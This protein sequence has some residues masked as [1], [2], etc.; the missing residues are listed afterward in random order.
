MS[1]RTTLALLLPLALACG[2]ETVQAPPTPRFDWASF[3]D[4]SAGAPDAGRSRDY[5]LERAAV[6]AYVDALSGRTLASLGKVLDENAHVSALGVEDAHGREKVIREHERL[7]GAFDGRALRARR[8]VVQRG[9]AVVEWRMTGTQA[10]EWMGVAPTGRAVSIEGV[11]LVTTQD[12]G[13]V[14]DV[15]VMFDVGAAKAQLASA[16]APSDSPANPEWLEPGGSEAETKNA[17]VVRAWLDAL[18]VDRPEPGADTARRTQQ[19]AAAD[20]ATYVDSLTDDVEVRQH[21]ATERGKDAARAYFKTMRRALAQLDVTTLST[22]SA[23]SV[24]AIEYTMGGDQLASFASVPLVADRVVLVDTVDVL[25]L[26]GG[27]IARVTRYDDLDAVSAARP[28]LRDA[29]DSNAKPPL[30]AGPGS[31]SNAPKAGR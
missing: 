22:A 12:D 7:F 18:E 16:N 4:A 9:S 26:R 5:A 17:E 20:E 28:G 3:D 25:E 29:A 24:V 27:K 21:G 31:A 8:V 10:R 1:S 6:N 2:S 13:E 15:R 30:K 23:G 19:G 11:T 14:S